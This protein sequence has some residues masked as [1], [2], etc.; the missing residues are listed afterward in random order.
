MDRPREAPNARAARSGAPAGD[1]QRARAGKPGAVAMGELARRR[2]GK[3][4]GALSCPPRAVGPPRLP[5]ACS[6]RR[7]M[8]SG[9]V[10]RERA[11]ADEVLSLDPPQEHLPQAAHTEGEAAL[12]DRA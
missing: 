7:R 9:G 5:V 8:V 6:P 1:G 12:A 10:A 3:T 4:P 11:G 2:E